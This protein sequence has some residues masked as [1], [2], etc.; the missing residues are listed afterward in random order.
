MMP[1]I[2]FIEHNGAQKEV[3]AEVGQT[4]MQAA[5]NNIVPGIIGDCG[6]ACSC[7]TCHGYIDA[8][9]IEHVPPASA[10]EAAMLE[11]AMHIQ[12]NSR[13]TCQ[14]TVTPELDGLII[15]LPVSQF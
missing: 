12:D 7:A 13:L 8:A 11:C 9:W 15:R 2:T 14:I 5:I 1:K 6:G 10:D 3:Q 4:V